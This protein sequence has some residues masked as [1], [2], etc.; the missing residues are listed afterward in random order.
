MRR[1]A[2]SLQIRS[3]AHFAKALL[4]SGRPLPPRT[5]T[6]G[7]L[8]EMLRRA[9]LHTPQCDCV[10]TSTSARMRAPKRARVECSGS[11]LAVVFPFPVFPLFPVS[12]ADDHTRPANDDA[13]SGGRCV[14]LSPKYNNELASAYQLPEV[15]SRSR[16]S[17]VRDSPVL[18]GAQ[19]SLTFLSQKLAVCDGLK[20]H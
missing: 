3:H 16:A 12:V 2:A 13:R 10:A 4:L 5:P 19:T 17:S 14:A 1:L 6:Y 11:G 9:I 20:E 8:C 7:R 18:P 15:S